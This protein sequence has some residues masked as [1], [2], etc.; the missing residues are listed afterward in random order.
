MTTRT[1]YLFGPWVRG[2]SAAFS[3][4]GRDRCPHTPGSAHAR[5]WLAGWDAWKR[6]APML[7]A[8]PAEPPPGAREG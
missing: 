6:D 1:K 2:A 8:P 5:A 7:E 4:G 3:G